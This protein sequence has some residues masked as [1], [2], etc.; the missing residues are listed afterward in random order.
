MHYFHRQIDQPETVRFPKLENKEGERLPAGKGCNGSRKQLN[1]ALKRSAT[2]LVAKQPLG[3]MLC[4]FLK[5]RRN[6]K[7][8]KN[9]KG[10]D[11]L[12]YVGGCQ[13]M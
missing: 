2:A 4:V 10:R 13:K 6:A 5:L 9:S 1:G 7:P 8:E 11:D 12:F 3:G